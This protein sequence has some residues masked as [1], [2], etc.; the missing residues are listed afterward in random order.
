MISTITIFT[1]TVLGII[2][3]M[4]YVLW[5]LFLAGMNL[6]RANND[7]RLTL[8]TKIFGWPVIVLTVIIDAFLN[9]TIMTVVLLELP[10]EWTISARLRRHNQDTGWRKNIA[11]FFE[12]FLDPYD[13]TGN[14][15]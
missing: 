15:I 12:Q 6:I 8:A 1:S 14:H 10:R 5:V 13:P 9:L 3:A 2:L 11:R 4:F 7:G